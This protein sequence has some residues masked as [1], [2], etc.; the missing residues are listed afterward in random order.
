MATNGI[1]LTI[2]KIMARDGRNCWLCGLPVYLRSRM[3]DLSP[4]IDHVVRRCEGGRNHLD[5]YRL[6]HR[7]CNTRRHDSDGATKPKEFWKE[8]RSRLFDWYGDVIGTAII[9]ARENLVIGKRNIA[10]VNKVA[11]EAQ[12]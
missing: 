4:S 9:D 1:K 5:N 11:R 2:V 12:I 6:A 7:I 10:K 3:H 8:L